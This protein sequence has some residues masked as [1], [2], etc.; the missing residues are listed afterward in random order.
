LKNPNSQLIKAYY[1]A[2]NGVLPVFD[3]IAP[4]NASG[5]YIVLADRTAAQQ[6]DKN[7]FFTQVTVVIDIVTTGQNTGFKAA[8]QY[9]NQV[10]EII[11]SNETL[12]MDDF[13]LDSQV[14][15]SINNLSGLDPAQKMFRVLIRVSSYITQKN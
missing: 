3:G 11:N 14:I 12:T 15:E 13:T 10:L 6:A 1:N 7:N 5:N 8:Q 9:S 2:L 4:N